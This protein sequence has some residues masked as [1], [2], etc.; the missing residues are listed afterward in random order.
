MLKRRQKQEKNEGGEAFK[1]SK[2]SITVQTYF[3]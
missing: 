1:N 3:P 2:K